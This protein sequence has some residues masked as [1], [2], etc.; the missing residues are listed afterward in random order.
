MAEDTEKQKEEPK[1]VGFWESTKR[2]IA[3]T[4]G[5]ADLAN[6]IAKGASDTPDGLDPSQRR[7]VETSIEK[8]L[9]PTFDAI[10]NLITAGTFVSIG[11]L[12][13]AIVSLIVAVVTLIVA[14]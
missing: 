10:Q 1:N 11:S 5:V 8:Q 9:K 7:L 14:T 3:L 13:V 6:I 12:L 4:K 2:T